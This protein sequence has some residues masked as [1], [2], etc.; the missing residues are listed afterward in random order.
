[1]ETAGE[2]GET[3]HGV[4]LLSELLH[5][6]KLQSHAFTEHKRLIRVSFKGN[7]GKEANRVSVLSDV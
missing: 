6:N 7:V 1:M 3:Q 4:V 2:G 5:I